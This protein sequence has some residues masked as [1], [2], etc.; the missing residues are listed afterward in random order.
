MLIELFSLLFV[1]SFVCFYF[2]S[3][4]THMLVHLTALAVSFTDACIPPDVPGR[5]TAVPCL[6][7][8]RVHQ[9][10]MFSL[11]FCFFSSIIERGRDIANILLPSHVS[12]IFPVRQP[13]HRH[14]ARAR[15]IAAKPCPCVISSLR[16]LA[17]TPL[18]PFE[19]LPVR[20]C[21]A[22]KP[23]PCSARSCRDTAHATFPGSEDLPLFCSLAR[24][25][26]SPVR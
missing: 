25:E 17:R 18:S 23:C 10:Y 8:V 11:L 16:S 13:L 6:L 2:C 15:A 1:C 24:S 5:V 9:F 26:A 21:L 7:C 4:Q 22:A 12:Q 14:L 3:F 19:A 20:R